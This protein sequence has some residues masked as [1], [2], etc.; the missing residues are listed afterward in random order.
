VVALYILNSCPEFGGI[1]PVRLTVP[2]AAPVS[3]TCDTFSGIVAALD[4]IAMD[5]S[6]T[7]IAPLTSSFVPGVV[8]PMPTFCAMPQNEAQRRVKSKSGFFMILIIVLPIY[9][10]KH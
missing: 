4:A 2:V 9:T 10:A 7:V 3:R 8:V 1:Q 6:R 5:V